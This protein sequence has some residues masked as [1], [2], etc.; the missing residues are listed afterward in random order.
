MTLTTTDKQTTTSIIIANFK[1]QVTELTAG[2]QSLDKYVLQDLST[3]FYQYRQGA[4]DII[5]L[6]KDKG[7]REN[8]IWQIDQI[9]YDFN[10]ALHKKFD[11]QEYAAQSNQYRMF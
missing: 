3:K 8:L 2:I 5:Y 6:F 7:L 4:I 9:G 11:D 10:A 1:R